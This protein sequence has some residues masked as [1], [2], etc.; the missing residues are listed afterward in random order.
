MNKVYVMKILNCI[1]LTIL[2]LAGISCGFGAEL[3]NIPQI[4][5]SL[6][7][8]PL[9]KALVFAHQSVGADLMKGLDELYEEYGLESPVQELNAGSELQAGTIYHFYAGENTKPDT[10][11]DA[12]SSVVSS[13]NTELMAGVKFCWIDIHEG[14]DPQ[15]LFN[16]Y[17]SEVEHM[18]AVNPDVELIHFTTPIHAIQEGPKA[19]L[20]AFLGRSP[21]EL[22][23]NILREEYNA[24]LR[25]KYGERVF[26]LAK[27]ESSY[28]EGGDSIKTFKGRTAKNLVAEFT[29]DGGHLNKL[30][31]RVVAVRF[32]EFLHN[33]YEG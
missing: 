15:V 10:K 14:M 30:G 25:A 29:Y 33:L 13:Q 23:N 3:M 11:L 32:V 1:A 24:L 16:Q 6:L 20:K 18:L 31:R 8:L 7:K 9:S 26:D 17:V 2:I 19:W 21:R 27:Y 12:F 4:D 28:P 5:T 22:E